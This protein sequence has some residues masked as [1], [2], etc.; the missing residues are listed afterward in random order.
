MVEVLLTDGELVALG[1]EQA[2]ALGGADGVRQASPPP[3]R[4]LLTQKLEVR[5]GGAGRSPRPRSPSRRT[6]GSRAARGNRASPRARGRRR[7]PRGEGARVGRVLLLP[8]RVR[9]A[10]GRGR[11]V[12]TVGAARGASPGVARGP[13]PGAE[14]STPRDERSWRPRAVT[15]PG[16]SA[17]APRRAAARR[18]PD[19][20]RRPRAPTGHRAR[21]TEEGASVTARARRWPPPP[22]ATR[23]EEVPV[24]P[25]HQRRN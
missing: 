7:P 21:A 12:R 4:D 13:D 5:A 18:A 17:S 15:W 23:R 1:R 14:R 25:C 22:P 3:A 9:I 6:P 8:G 10:A 20:G 11:V 24:E 2:P 19:A 16:G